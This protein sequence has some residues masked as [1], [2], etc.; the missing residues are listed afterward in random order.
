MATETITLQR[1]D[2]LDGDLVQSQSPYAQ[3]PGLSL[4]ESPR[5][6]SPPTATA[7]EMGGGPD[8]REVTPLAPADR[9][10][11]AWAFLIAAT[12][13]ET[14]VWGLLNAVGILQQY[15]ST[16]QFPGND[17]TVTL[18]TSLMNGLSFMGAGAF[19]P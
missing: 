13:I 3:T 9:G 4:P 5:S 17:S 11:D 19:G 16:K 8:D 7:A 10:K 6:A 14:T 15:W 12:V 1:L 2:K 18:A